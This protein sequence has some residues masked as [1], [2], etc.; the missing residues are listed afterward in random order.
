MV[1]DAESSVTDPKVPLLGDTT[2]GVFTSVLPLIVTDTEDCVRSSVSTVKL[3]V[4]VSEAL[5]ASTVVL[6]LSSV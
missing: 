4:S 5:R 1:C 3:S 6:A 2:A